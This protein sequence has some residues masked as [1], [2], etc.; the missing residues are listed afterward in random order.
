MDFYDR[1]LEIWI[2]YQG[3][4]DARRQFLWNLVHEDENDI[5]QLED[6]NTK[7][8]LLDYAHSRMKNGYLFIG[9][10]IWDI[11][12]LECKDNYIHLT[13]N[14][15]DHDRLLHKI[16][17]VPP[18]IRLNEDVMVDM[19]FSRGKYQFGVENFIF[20]YGTLVEQYYEN[21]YRD[22]YNFWTP[23]RINWHGPLDAVSALLADI[24]TENNTED[25]H[26]RGKR[27]HLDEY[28]DEKG[29]FWRCS[30][31]D[32]DI[33]DNHISFDAFCLGND[34]ESVIEMFDALAIAHSA[35]DFEMKMQLYKDESED[36]IKTRIF[37]Y[38]NG[39]RI[40]ELVSESPIEGIDDQC[41]GGVGRL[42][43]RYSI[44]EDVYEA[45]KK[46]IEAVTEAVQ[47]NILALKYVPEKLMTAEFCLALVKQ[48][49][50][51]LKFLPVKC[52][53]DE[54]CLAAVQEDRSALQFVPEALK[55][56]VEE[57]YEIDD[58]DDDGITQG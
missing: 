3:S 34:K 11:S 14:G 56:K 2:L 4:E 39:K 36:E 6:F 49:G 10:V 31:C 23:C 51:A 29:P 42:Y 54:V 30:I 32:G 18:C 44:S 53:T 25:D 5:K 13:A 57:A 19:S 38:K 1:E 33:T 48:N 21:S 43:F 26:W 45:R 35:L 58:E 28:Y 8:D 7:D 40:N 41:A 47:H 24:I 50:Y 17:D 12:I 16:Y 37:N 52:K 46:G 55:S 20:Q 22:N 27:L 9:T 15:E